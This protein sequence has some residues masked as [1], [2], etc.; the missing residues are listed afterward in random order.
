MKKH[1]LSFFC[2][3]LLLFTALSSLGTFATEPEGGDDCPT[4]E[5][6]VCM[7]RLANDYAN[8][9]QA[10][11][12]DYWLHY[13]KGRPLRNFDKWLLSKGFLPQTL[14]T[15]DIRELLPPVDRHTGEIYY[16]E[17]LDG[18]VGEWLFYALPEGITVETLR[19]EYYNLYYYD[20]YGIFD[21][22]RKHPGG[23][24]CF[25]P[26]FRVD[27]SGRVYTNCIEIGILPEDQEFWENE[28]MWN[29]ARIAFKDSQKII[30]TM[31]YKLPYGQVEGDTTVEYRKTP[32]GWRVYN[33]AFMG[34]VGEPPETGDST[35]VLLTVTALSVL[36]LCA[37]AV[38]VGRRKKERF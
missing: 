9:L 21:C 11:V 37:L 5:E 6:L 27:D 17:G 36:G 23:G 32:N 22:T 15:K 3:C 38:A 25:S 1:I 31:H 7:A 12:Y 30:L 14:E 33:S 10:G 2:A 8:F 20:K 16:G 13:S 24:K 18:L 35:P 29:S 34:G 26:Y 4:V 19:E 28:D